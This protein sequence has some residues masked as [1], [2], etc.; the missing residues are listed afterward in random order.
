MDDG[1]KKAIRKDFSDA[2]NMTPTEIEDWLESDESKSVG[3]GQ[4]ESKGHRSGRRI[5][6]IKEKSVDDLTGDDYSHMNRVV[7]YVARH[8]KQRPSGDVEDT[9]WTYSLK[10]WGH[11]PTK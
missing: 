3:E 6:E 1:E 10:N 8:V 5:I 11:D 9:D 2:V 7:G 4:G